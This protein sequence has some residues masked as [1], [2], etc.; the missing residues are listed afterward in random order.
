MAETHSQLSPIN[1][2]A[3][4]DV[5]HQLEPEIERLMD[6]H[7]APTRK[8][9]SDD[10]QQELFPASEWN[11][12]HLIP[13]DEAKSYDQEKQAWPAPAAHI[14]P[15][16]GSAL[17]INT[18]TEDIL[19]GY[20]HEIMG[21]AERVNSKAFREWAK[22]WTYEESRHGRVMDGFLAATRLVDP[23]ELEA[24][25]QSQMIKGEVPHAKTAVQLLA[26]TALQER[27][28]QIAH[29]NTAGMLRK[30]TQQGEPDFNGVKIMA[31]VAA[32]EARHYRFYAGLFK[33]ALEIDPSTAIVA[34]AH[35]MQGFM[36][37]GRDIPGFRRHAI[38]IDKA[39]IYGDAEL[40]DDVIKPVLNFVE[41]GKAADG[42]KLTTEAETG[43]LVI[44]SY[45]ADKETRVA[46]RQ[47]ALARRAAR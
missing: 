47:A 23:D 40:L 22:L 19:P 21:H 16:V 30:D 37:P 43:K 25:R 41:Y 45:I 24:A 12:D 44:A 32:D 42:K 39:G 5:L 27:A 29:K 7:V 1:E 26:Y 17:Y 34:L 8:Q 11:P 18:I 15:A 28:T 6:V 14:S 20:H 38:Q 33:K 36:M 3:D 13:Y 31:T 35:E 2:Y 9:K 10:Q 46:K 4:L